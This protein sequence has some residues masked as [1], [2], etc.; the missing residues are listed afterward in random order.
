MD[1]NWKCH[2]CGDTR[3][4]EKISVHKHDR[5]AEHGMPAGTWTENVRYCNDRPACESGA[6][7]HRFGDARHAV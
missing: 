5:S 7:E 6:R 2:I 4:D 1:M 3:P